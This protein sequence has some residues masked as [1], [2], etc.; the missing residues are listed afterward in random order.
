MKSTIQSIKEDE[1]DVRMIV[2]LSEN[3]FSAEF[4]Q[5][6]SILSMEE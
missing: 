5:L 3:E 1:P 2:F 4:I 6:T